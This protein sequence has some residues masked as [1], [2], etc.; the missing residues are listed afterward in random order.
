VPVFVD[1]DPDTFN[2]SVEKFETAVKGFKKG[3]LQGLRPRAVMPVDLFGLPCDYDGIN[4]IAREHDLVVIEDAAQ[5]FGA[6]Y[7]G[8][9]AGGLGHIGCTSFF[10]VQAVGV[11]WG[12]G[13]G[14]H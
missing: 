5:S 1:I 2:I 11:L 7:K 14:F 6:E 8:R 3:P 10:P 9:M 13:S 12:W 4:K